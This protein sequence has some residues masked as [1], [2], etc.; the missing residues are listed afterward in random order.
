MFV[1]DLRKLKVQGASSIALES[2]EYLLDFSGKHGF[3]K[4]FDKECKKLLE[5][6]PTAVVLF[7]A[8][9][10]V[11][12]NRTSGEIK[13]VIS[14][15]EKAKEKTALNASKLFLSKTAVMTHCHSSFE[16]A[17]LIRNK[18]KIRYVI[19][20]ETRP[21]NQGRIT[22]RELAAHN[23]PVL[24]IADDA[25]SDEISKTDIVMVG[26]DALRKEGLVNKVG[27]HPLA[28]VAKENGKPFY[29][30]TSSFTLDKRKKFVIEKRPTGE[31]GF[32]LKGIAIDNP[33]FDITPW[34]YVSL[35]VTEKG[36]F[37]PPQIKRMIT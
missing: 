24:F 26:A 35:I 12:K 2:M 7:N 14:E 25:I 33:A 15:L 17:A 3:G 1:S 4:E 22:A 6:R 31:L 30:V 29:V 32:K 20:T 36:I 37:K 19:V 21:K 16:V 13:R 34:K 9:Q 18:K 28:L 27:T 5:S 11:R 8:I 23:I 10:R